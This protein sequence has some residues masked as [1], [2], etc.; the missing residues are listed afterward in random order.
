MASFSL[1]GSKSKSSS[2]TIQDLLQKSIESS[3]ANT[4]GSTNEVTT[5]FDEFSKKKLDTLLFCSKSCTVVEE[6]LLLLPPK[7][8]MDII[9][10]S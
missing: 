9:C 2:T 1:G 8:N 6:L 4:V 7:L 3:T 10:T 5:A